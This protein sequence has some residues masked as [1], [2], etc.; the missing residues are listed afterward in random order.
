MTVVGGM[1]GLIAF[2]ALG[3][4]ALAMAAP[5]AL[6]GWGVYALYHKH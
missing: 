5:G 6:A 3:L 1:T 4:P 2:V